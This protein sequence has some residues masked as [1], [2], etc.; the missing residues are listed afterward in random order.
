MILS[1]KSFG[2]LWDNSYIKFAIL[3]IKFQFTCGD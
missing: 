2:N 3:D 1:L